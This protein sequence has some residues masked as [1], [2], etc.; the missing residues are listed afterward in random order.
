MAKVINCV[1]GHDIDVY[2]GCVFDENSR[3]YT[4]GVKIGSIPFSGKILNVDFKL[5][6]SASIISHDTVLNTKERQRIIRISELPPAEEYDFCIV[7][8]TYLSA[9]KEL[10]IDTSKLLTIEG[11][12]I[13]DNGKVIGAY[14]FNRN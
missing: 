12:V 10:G 5:K 7:S 11:S 3:K 8:N 9:C 2:D 13:D 4:G 14:F 1:G 6:D